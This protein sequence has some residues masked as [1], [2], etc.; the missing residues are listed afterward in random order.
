MTELERLEI[1]LK[2]AF[3]KQG[4]T[5][6]GDMAAFLDYKRTYFSDVIRGASPI[7]DNF[8]K[9]ISD[10]L[11]INTDWIKTGKGEMINKTSH[12]VSEP[13]VEYFKSENSSTHLDILTNVIDKLSDSE[14]RNSKNIESLSESVKE[15]IAQ[16]RDQVDNITKLVNYLCQNGVDMENPLKDEQKRAIS[17]LDKE[18]DDIK[19][20]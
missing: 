7:S 14:Q 13:A 18:Q 6:K 1:A 10:K 4:I 11:N 12:I 9:I 15:L 2:I 16:N 3:N 19:A 17:E 5:K 8:L 20:M